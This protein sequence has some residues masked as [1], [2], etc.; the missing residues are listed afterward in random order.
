MLFNPDWSLKQIEL[1]MLSNVS[2]IQPKC[3][4]YLQTLYKG[5][6]N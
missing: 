4:P 6:N 3:S 5:W 1:L 2:E